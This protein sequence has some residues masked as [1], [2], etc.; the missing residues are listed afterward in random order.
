[1]LLDALLVL[2]LQLIF[3]PTFTLRTI[4]LIKGLTYRAALFGFI[5]A[6]I[7]LFG[8]SIVFS[9]E[10]STVTMIVY[11]VGFALGILIGTKIENELAIG[12]TTIQVI[13]NNKN[14]SLIEQLRTDGYGV[15]WHEVEGKDAKRY[16]LEILTKR[17][18]EEGLIEMIQESEPY[19][20]IIAYEPKSF[21][22]GFI[23]KA[24]KKRKKKKKEERKKRSLS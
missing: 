4:F 11:A 7:Y 18:Q 17:N 2:V 9:G 23:L 3:V 8:L 15:S 5:E 6:L 16:K 10:Q 1:M 19:A 21:K 14:T 12:Y 22:G 20:F 24:M 13:L